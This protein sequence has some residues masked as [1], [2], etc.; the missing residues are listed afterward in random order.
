[1]DLNFAIQDEISKRMK[2]VSQEKNPKTRAD[3][4]RD[5]VRIKKENL[6]RQADKKALLRRDF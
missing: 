2:L 5:I 1:M 4:V 6:I 3:L